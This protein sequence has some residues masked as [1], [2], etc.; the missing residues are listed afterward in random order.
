MNFPQTRP[1]RSAGHSA[2]H[3]IRTL[4]LSA[5][6]LLVS[7][8]AAVTL[9]PVALGTEAGIGK[10]AN[11]SNGKST[12]DATNTTTA[13]DASD[14]QES[15]A[16]PGFGNYPKVTE[17]EQQLLGKTYVNDPLPTRLTRLEVKQFGKGST[18]DLCDRMDKLDQFLKPKS[19]YVND[20]EDSASN[21]DNGGAGGSSADGASASGTS[22]T[23]S[24][25]GNYPK[26]TALEEKLLKQTY[27]NEP[28]PARLARLETKEFNKTWPDEAL[29][30]RLDRLDKQVNPKSARRAHADAPG[31]DADQDTD[32]ADHGTMGAIGKALVGL[33]GGTVSGGNGIGGMGMGPGL[34]GGLSGMGPGGGMSGGTGRRNRNSQ[35]TPPNAEPTA[36][37]SRNPFAEGTNAVVGVGPRLSAMEKFIFGREFTNRPVEERLEKLEKKLVPYEHHTANDD[38]ARRVDHLWSLLAES[39]KSKKAAEPHQSQASSP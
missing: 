24:A 11:A 17:L 36:P 15:Y 22:D 13:N 7:F 31:Q 33:L 1:E 21:S 8:A 16:K 10:L 4:A 6:P 28:L 23:D 39:N 29:C 30:D 35:S 38:A 37:V 14:G 26:V 5:Y 12:A 32:T 2:R 27:V 19:G 20:D 18:G 34:L 9:S 3:I 25:P